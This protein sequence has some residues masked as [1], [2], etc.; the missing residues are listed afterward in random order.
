[1]KKF[2]LFLVLIAVQWTFAQYDYQVKNTLTVGPGMVY[3]HVTVPEKLWNINILEI[4]LTNP[5][6]KIETVKAKNSYI[7]REPTSAMAKRRSYEGHQV[8]GAINGDFFSS[9]GVPINVQV[10]QGQILRNPANLST[11]GFNLLNR[12]SLG[13]VSLKGVVITKNGAKQING[14]NSMRDTDQTV[15]YNSLFGET[16]NTNQWGIE[17]LVKPINPWIVNDTVKVIVEAIEKYAG[18]MSIPENY[19]VISAHGESIPFF[20]NNTST[21]DTLSLVLQLTPS[22]PGLTEM[23]G[24]FPK[25]VFNGKNYASQGYNE[26]GG[27]PHAFQVHPRTSVGFSQDSTRLYFFTVDGRKSGVFKGMTLPE[28]ADVMIHFG[29]AQ[30]LNLDGG[31]STTFVIRNEIKNHPSDGSERAVANALLAVSSAPKGDFGYI[32]IEPDNVSLYYNSVQQFTVSG[33]DEYYNPYP[34]QQ[35]QLYFSVDSS[36]G[37]V[38]AKGLFRAKANGGSGY[39]YAHYPNAVDSAYVFIKPVLSIDLQPEYAVTDTITPLEFIVNAIA[40]DGQVVH[41]SPGVYVWRAVN[42]MIGEV[43]ENGKFYGKSEGETQVIASLG[44]ISDTVTVRVEIGV[45]ET[46]LDSLDTPEDWKL[47]GENFD[48]LSTNLSIDTEHFTFGRGAL[49]LDYAYTYSTSKPTNFYLIKKI[50]IYGVP[51]K[52]SIDFKSDGQK[53][54]LYFVVSDNN[55]ELYKS[56]KR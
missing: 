49:R 42:P 53:H 28:L 45:D 6:I 52:I 13:I 40:E 36:L 37:T 51:S 48:S 25:I 3:K 12:P 7:G 1:M 34:L 21:G 4:D 15:L 44:D 46:L 41:L 8:V 54:K 47:S 19:A 16:T 10:V 33:W 56:D 43:D 32:Q 9:E 26:E 50:P 20:E 18:N 27:P 2:V 35:N 23:M 22:L 55:G 29:V 11:I 14:V 5:F 39:V 24:G 31:G 30:G 17:L 38:D